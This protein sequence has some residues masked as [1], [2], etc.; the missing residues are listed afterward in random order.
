MKILSSKGRYFILK[1]VL[2]AGI[3]LFIVSFYAVRRFENR[4]IYSDFKL[5]TSYYTEAL[6]SHI[7]GHLDW[8]HSI[9][10]F[11]SASQYVDRNEFSRFTKPILL[12][13]PG[14]IE[15]SWI[16]RVLDDPM[17]HVKVRKTGGKVT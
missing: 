1:L 10:D 9:S 4:Q 13:H 3:I 7:L 8:L 16:P 5:Q 14:I 2:G 11:Y 15:L 6:K 17:S 12:R